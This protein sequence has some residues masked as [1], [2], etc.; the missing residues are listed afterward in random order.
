MEELLALETRPTAVVCSN[1]LT[2][3]GAL[4]AAQAAGLRIPDDISIICR[5]SDLDIDTI[6]NYI[7][8][9]FTSIDEIKRVSRLGMGPCQGRNC[10]PL[11]LTELS[12]AT[13]IPVAELSPGSYRPV[14]RSV[15]LG[16]VADYARQ[17]AEE[18]KEV[19]RD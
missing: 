16:A 12:R 19:L 8:C 17:E 13:G 1:D 18:V 9:G 10:I 6:R 14:T 2:A 7:N 11:V 4:V 15:A 3:V 5:C